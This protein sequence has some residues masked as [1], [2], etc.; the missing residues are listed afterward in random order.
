MERA[1]STYRPSYRRLIAQ[2]LAAI[3]W[4]ALMATLARALTGYEIGRVFAVL[5]LAAVTCIVCGLVVATRWAMSDGGVPQFTLNSLLW[6]SVPLAV[7]FALSG[8]LIRSHEAR[9]GEM[10]AHQI[11]LLLGVC[12]IGIVFS[13]PALLLSAESLVWF[14]AVFIRLPTMQRLIRRYR[15]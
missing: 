15:R 12:I 11:V 8:A 7:Y 5:S 4:L 3:S 13:L 14:A 2:L 10:S 1:T 6:A 9:F